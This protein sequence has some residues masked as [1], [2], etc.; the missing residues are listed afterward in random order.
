MNTVRHQ[1]ILN[2]VLGLMMLILGIGFFA[3]SVYI[4]RHPPLPVGNAPLIEGDV[5]TCERTLVMLRERVHRQGNALFVQQLASNFDNS[6][7]M[8]S[9]ASIGISACGLPLI[10]LCMGPACRVHG[11][12][13]VLPTEVSAVKSR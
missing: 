8:L 5:S 12:S 10:E 4:Y 6:K 11:L 9:N 3:G 2:T 13:F 7:R 1:R